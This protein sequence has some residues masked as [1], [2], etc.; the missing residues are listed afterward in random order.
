M[1]NIGMYM[2][3][4]TRPTIAP[5]SIIITGSITDVSDLSWAATSSS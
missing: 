4:T 5:T 3:M 2:A 1:L